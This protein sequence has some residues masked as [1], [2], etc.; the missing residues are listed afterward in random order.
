MRFAAMLCALPVG[1]CGAD[2][3]M[4]ESS[5]LDALVVVVRNSD[6]DPEIGSALEI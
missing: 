1:V 5:A 3:G 2:A 4:V 6:K